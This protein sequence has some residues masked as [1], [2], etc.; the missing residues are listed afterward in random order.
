MIFAF[1]KAFFTVLVRE[2]KAVA[3]VFM[4]HSAE[5]RRIVISVVLSDFRVS[6]YRVRS[7]Q[8]EGTAFGRTTERGE[9]DVY[10]IPA[11]TVSAGML[12]KLRFTQNGQGISLPVL[13]KNKIFRKRIIW[14]KSGCVESL[15]RNVVKLLKFI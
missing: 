14:T 8:T 9:G 12:V 4:H 1:A 2:T 13:R 5:N 6:L 7:N 10:Y 3:E 15:R 11:E